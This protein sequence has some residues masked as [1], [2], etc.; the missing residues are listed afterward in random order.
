MNKL[1]YLDSD[2]DP[3]IPTKRGDSICVGLTDAMYGEPSPRLF[4]KFKSGTLSIYLTREE[5]AALL[6]ALQMVMDKVAEGG[7]E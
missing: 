7:D 5:G 1:I 4:I 6:E 2:G 3:V